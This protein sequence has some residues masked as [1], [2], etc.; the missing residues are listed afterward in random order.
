MSFILIIVLDVNILSNIFN[1]INFEMVVL[2]KVIICDF[3]IIHYC[4]WYLWLVVIL[5]ETIEHFWLIHVVEGWFFVNIF[6]L[7]QGFVT[8][9]NT[10]FHNW[11]CLF[12]AFGICFWVFGSQLGNIFIFWITIVD[13]KN[14]FALNLWLILLMS[15]PLSCL[16]VIFLSDS[17]FKSWLSDNVWI[18][19]L[20]IWCSLLLLSTEDFI[21]TFELFPLILY[22]FENSTQGLIS[23]RF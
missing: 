14:F 21:K 1:L 16:S 3:R 15:L 7:L 13:D 22:L 6:L 11:N 4:G 19:C 12:C 20:N 2:I 10:F 17:I 23:L 9:W 18:I 5:L 8:L